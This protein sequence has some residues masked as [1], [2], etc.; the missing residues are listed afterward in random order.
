MTDEEPIAVLMRELPL[1]YRQAEGLGSLLLTE[2][3]N[4]AIMEVHQ[5]SRERVNA[6]PASVSVDCPPPRPLRER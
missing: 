5:L 3:L 2:L 1:L 6:S 4:N